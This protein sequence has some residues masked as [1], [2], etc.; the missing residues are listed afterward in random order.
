MSDDGQVS[1][2]RDA[3]RNHAALVTAAEV[4]FA[5]EGPDVPL[6]AVVR[7][8]GVGRGTLYRHFTGRID[9]AAAVYERHIGEHEAY[10]VEHRD[11]P[12]L[13][14]YLLDRMTG[15]QARTRGVMLVLA[16]EPEGE[17]QIE[18]LVDRLRVLLEAALERARE[19]GLVSPSVTVEDLLLVLAM[20]EGALVGAPLDDAPAIA[21]RVVD[22][23]TPA[24]RTGPG[25]GT[26]PAPAPHLAPA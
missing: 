12:D 24:L 13:L 5:T 10:A 19:A 22:L 20:V 26:T 25:L 11:E 4:E 8:A 16:R 1:R 23:V 3:R 17:A 15:V 2:R 18:R 21:K 9:L 6:D 14:Y 7:R